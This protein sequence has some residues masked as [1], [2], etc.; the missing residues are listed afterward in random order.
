MT[1]K[2][3]HPQPTGIHVPAPGSLPTPAALP[4]AIYPNIQS[5]GPSSQQYGVVAGNWPVAR[6]ALLPGSY[7]QGSY[8]PVILPPGMVPLAGWNPYQVCALIFQNWP[9]MLIST[10]IICCHMTFYRHL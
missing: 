6:P 7:I 10:Y 2:F 3:H 1:C 5:P 4:S 9:V 8:G